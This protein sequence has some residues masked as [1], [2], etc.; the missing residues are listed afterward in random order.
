MDRLECIQY[1]LDNACTGSE[2]EEAGMFTA[3][4]EVM[5]PR[6]GHHFGPGGSG[7]DEKV[8]WLNDLLEQARSN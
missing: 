8:A 4:R 3:I 2:W 5:S 7:D 6:S 1:L